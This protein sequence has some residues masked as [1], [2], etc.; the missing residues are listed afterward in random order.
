MPTQNSGEN[1]EKRRNLTP[2]KPGHS[3]NPGGRPKKK[4]LTEALEAIYADPKEAMAAAK[5]LAKKVRK[6]SIAHF[7][8]AANRLEGKVESSDESAG[9]VTFN[10]I[11][12]AP[13]PHRPAIRRWQQTRWAR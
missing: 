7:Q 12:S 3:G 10:V 13:R 5:A 8:E 6:G 9:G 4:L 11:I 2:W 1:S